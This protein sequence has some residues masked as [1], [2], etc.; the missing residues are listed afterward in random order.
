MKALKDIG[1]EP[2]ATR[3]SSFS[4][5]LSYW[6]WEAMEAGV[7]VEEKVTKTIVFIGQANG[8]F[9]AH[10]TGFLGV[11]F[12]GESVFQQIVTARHVIDGIPGN[13]VQVRVNRK[14]GEAEII[15]I[16]KDN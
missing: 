13:A 6:A 10:G 8:P 7:R 16:P 14:D 4:S 15:K 3:Y 11:N 5:I 12:I 9:I 1:C 2:F